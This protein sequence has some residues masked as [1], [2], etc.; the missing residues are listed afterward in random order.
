[1]R[2]RYVQAALDNHISLYAPYYTATVFA[3]GSQNWSDFDKYV[4]PYLD[5]TAPTR[6]AGAK[7]TAVQVNGPSTTMV[8]GG[9]AKHFKDKGRPRRVRW[10][11]RAA[12]V[13]AAGALAPACSRRDWPSWWRHSCSATGAHWPRCAARARLV[14]SG[15]AQRHLRVKW[16]P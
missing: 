12:W 9:W 4:G 5:G 8:V 14:A 6:L 2:A 13:A 11:R 7:L 10:P 1:L 15:R 3:D 16:Q